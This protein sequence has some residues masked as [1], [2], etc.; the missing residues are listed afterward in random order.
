MWQSPDRQ[1][2]SSFPSQQR[3]NH[4]TAGP[5]SHAIR[6]CPYICVCMLCVFYAFLSSLQGTSTSWQGTAQVGKG[7]ASFCEQKEAKNSFNLCRAGFN[8]T[9]PKEQKT[10]FSKSSRFPH[11]LR[12]ARIH[13]TYIFRLHVLAFFCICLAPV[14]ANQE[15]STNVVQDHQREPT[16]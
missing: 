15:Q 5:A 10:A 14:S 16:A 3:P 9:G 6:K 4:E 1:A 13:F 2:T 7:R 8:T 12:I 11:S